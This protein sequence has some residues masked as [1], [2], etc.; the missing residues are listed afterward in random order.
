MDVSQVPPDEPGP[1]EAVAGHATKRGTY[2]AVTGRSSEVDV[3]VKRR[4]HVLSWRRITEN[5]RDSN[6]RHE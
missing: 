6:N 2:E 4:G 1:R 5:S 3:D